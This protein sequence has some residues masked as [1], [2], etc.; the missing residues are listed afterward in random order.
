M[1]WIYLLRYALFE[2][3]DY[4]GKRKPTWQQVWCRLRKH[5][6]GPIY[7]NV[8]GTE[9]DWKCIDCGEYLG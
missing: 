6:N 9:P 8:G 4:A 2:S 3:T 1:S 7:Y 5:P